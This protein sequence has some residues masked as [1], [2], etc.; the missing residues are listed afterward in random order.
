MMICGK[1]GIQVRESM[2]GVGALAVVAVATPVVV[3]LACRRAIWAMTWRFISGDNLKFCRAGKLRHAQT[4]ESFD[5]A[6]PFR[7]GA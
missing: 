1:S 3:S 5:L 2:G 7:R 4:V 6:A